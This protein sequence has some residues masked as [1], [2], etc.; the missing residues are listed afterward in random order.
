[1]VINVNNG[2]MGNIEV[3]KISPVSDELAKGKPSGNAGG[4]WGCKPDA[5]R[6]WEQ[7]AVYEMPHRLTKEHAEVTIGDSARVLVIDSKADVDRFFERYGENPHSFGD[8][9]YVNYSEVAK[10]YDVIDYHYSN[11]DGENGDRRLHALACDCVYVLN[12]DVIEDVRN[13]ET[14]TFYTE[15]EQWLLQE[16][17][18]GGAI[19][20]GI[21]CYNTF[22]TKAERIAALD[23]YYRVFGKNEG[24]ESAYTV[25]NNYGRLKDYIDRNNG[26]I[27]EKQLNKILINVGA[28]KD[29][30]R[31]MG[32]VLDDLREKSRGED[33]SKVD[34]FR[35]N[36]DDKY[37]H[38]CRPWRVQD[39]K[40]RDFLFKLYRIDNELVHDVKIEC[41]RAVLNDPSSNTWA[42]MGARIP[43]IAV[44]L[45]S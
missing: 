25:V 4:L 6:T 31:V 9:D 23:D 43:A 40:I 35:R 44:C 15:K 30:E 26:R 20:L 19:S 28:D 5:E 16:G 37:I 13:P 32:D 12:R 8:A 14:L 36:F 29:A 11:F 27:D 33:R 34:A 3:G 7:W 42:G 45:S 21:D 2:R 17:G 10:D 18:Y 41:L 1:M 38:G 22:D 24:S 39:L